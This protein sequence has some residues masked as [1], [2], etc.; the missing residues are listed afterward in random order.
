MRRWWEK[1]TEASLTVEAAVVLPFY[2]FFFL[3]LLS[4]MEM[5]HYSMT[6]DF[7]LSRISRQIAL[8][9]SAESLLEKDTAAQAQEV[10]Q[11]QDVGNGGSAAGEKAQGVAATVLADL[12]AS[13]TL[14]ARV[15]KAYRTQMGVY[16][17][18]SLWRSKVL[19]QDDLVDLIATA[20]LQPQCNAFAIPKQLIVNRARTHAWTGFC[21][22]AKEAEAK[23]RI[24]YVTENG[25]VYHLSRSCTHLDLTITP[26]ASGEVGARRNASGAVYRECEVCGGRFSTQETYYITPEGDRYHTSLGCNGLKRTIY[27]IPI[28][29]VGEK[30]ACSRC[31]GGL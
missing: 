11:A 31:G 18:L 14:N 26:V 22:N 1:K 20:Q 24:V 17:D 4:V 16:G 27:E 30:R 15:P 28:S 5:L 21:V 12:Y 29:Q 3:A 25:T 8:Y 13:E 6:M 2:L 9:A 19:L 7:E 23:E 10:Q